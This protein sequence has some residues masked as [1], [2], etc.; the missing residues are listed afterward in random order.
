MKKITIRVTDEMNDKLLDES[1]KLNISK[2]AYINILLIKRK[3]NIFD[4]KKDIFLELNRIGNNLNQLTKLA[5]SHIIN[6]VDLKDVKSEL[7]N[8][9]QFL[10]VLK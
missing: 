7:K 5:N 1:K 4:G 3:V 10:N 2:N 9:W 8:I 6:V